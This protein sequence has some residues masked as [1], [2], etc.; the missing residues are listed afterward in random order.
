MMWF[1]VSVP[2]CEHATIIWIVADWVS[3][4]PVLRHST[5]ILVD[6]VGVVVVM[7]SQTILLDD[8]HLQWVF[9]TTQNS[10]D[11]DRVSVVLLDWQNGSTRLI[12]R[13]SRL[14]EVQ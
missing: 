12:V 8:E 14:V 7:L 10:V 13:T 6:R 4:K 3:C 5:W 9:S 1:F 11:R 2:F